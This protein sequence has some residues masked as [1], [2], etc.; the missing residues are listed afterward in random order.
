[1][2]GSSAIA[3]LAENVASILTVKTQKLEAAPLR[4]GF[5]WVQMV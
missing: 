4:E 3:K 5:K 2:L 1:M